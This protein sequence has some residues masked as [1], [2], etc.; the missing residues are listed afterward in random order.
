MDDPKVAYPLFE[1]AAQA[2]IKVVAIHKALPLGAVPLDPYRVDDVDGAAIQFPE[3]NFEI[4]HS[5]MAFTEDT[6]LALARFPNVYANL[7]VT[8]HLIAKQGRRFGEVLAEL[9]AGAPHKVL[10]AATMPNLI[11]CQWLLERFVD[12]EFPEDVAER[13]DFQ[14]TRELK[15]RVLGLN[16]LEMVGADLDEVKAAI[17]DDEFSAYN[18]GANLEQW[19]TTWRQKSPELFV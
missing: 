13:Y 11:D 2:G 12:Y 5:G 9:M 14:L 1:A 18:D 10:W 15:E 7:E 3:L 17:A 19:G 4:I 6:A 8:T 16:Y